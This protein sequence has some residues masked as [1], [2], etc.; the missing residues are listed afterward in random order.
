MFWI[1]ITYLFGIIGSV[2]CSDGIFV[3][4]WCSFSSSLGLPS[5]QNQPLIL[6]IMDLQFYHCPICGNVIIK[7]SDGGTTPVCCG[8]E[9]E[10]MIPKTKDGFAEKHLPVVERCDHYT[11]EVKIGQVPH[12]MTAEHF[13]EFIC[14][15]TE[16]ETLIRYLSPGD[17]PVGL[18][19]CGDRPLAIYA[20]CNVHGL[21]KT[22]DVGDFG[23]FNNRGCVR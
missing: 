19:V 8:A 6:N 7:V 16:K 13:I 1:Q 18:F 12:P 9:M 21:W 11:Y 3:S 14:V 22:V 5:R 10:I 15:Q 4:L 20:Y 2:N 17:E 23:R